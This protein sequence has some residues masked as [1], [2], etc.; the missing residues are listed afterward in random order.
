ML[1]KMKRTIIDI[2]RFFFW[3][4]LRNILLYIGPNKMFLIE[5]P[6]SALTF[7]FQRGRR[8]II[9]R[10][11][12]KIY[13]KLWNEKRIKMAVKESFR[14]YVGFHVKNLYLSYLNS[15]TIERYI[16]VEGLQYLDRAIKQGKGVIIL[17][18]HFGP[19]LLMMPA[20]GYR[21]YIVNQLALHG[22]PPGGRSNLQQK[23]HEIKFRNVQGKMPATFIDASHKSNIRRAV[24][25]LNRNEIVL[26]P[27]TGR[28]GSKWIK[29]T[30]VN[31]TSLL[32]TGPIKMAKITGAALI[33]AFTLSG[34]PFATVILE[35][36]L[37]IEDRKVEEV[38]QEYADILSHY[39][40]RYPSHFSNYLYEMEINSQWDDHPFFVDQK[41]SVERAR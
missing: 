20:L 30:L 40:N 10:E 41:N 22:D 38:I 32:N 11:L 31:R 27:S 12:M 16:P 28:E 33:P 36:P 8:H 13:G 4:F 35:K 15:A 34:N 39:I 9:T 25:A 7:I 37:I 29:V 2:L 24:E 19:Y 3:G 18:P 23:I 6:I 1:Y 26:I 5:M 21:G 17:N 14:S